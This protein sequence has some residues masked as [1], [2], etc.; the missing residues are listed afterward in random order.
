LQDLKNLDSQLNE[1][2]DKSVESVLKRAGTIAEIRRIFDQI[3]N[4]L[5]KNR[6]TMVSVQKTVNSLSKFKRYSRLVLVLTIAIGL[7]AAFQLFIM[8]VL[9]GVIPR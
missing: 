7:F 2:I 1:Q 3:E 8:L 9:I 4:N 5:E 6:E